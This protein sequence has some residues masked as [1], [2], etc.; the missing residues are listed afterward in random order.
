MA[1]SRGL[2][3]QEKFQIAFD[4]PPL[5]LENHIADFATKVHDFTTKVLMYIMAGLLYIL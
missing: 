1:L 4:P 3:Y 2:Y 5:I